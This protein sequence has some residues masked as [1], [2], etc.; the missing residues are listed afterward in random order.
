[1]PTKQE[2]IRPE[3]HEHPLFNG[4]YHTAVWVRTWASNGTNDEPPDD[5]PVLCAI[6]GRTPN[7]Y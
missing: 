6:C 7:G 1:M 4:Q 3:Y 2:E 5:A